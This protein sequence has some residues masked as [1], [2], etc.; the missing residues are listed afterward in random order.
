VR[1]TSPCN[2]LLD[3]SAPARNTMMMETV[4]KEM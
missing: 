3:W 1:A 4:A 2:A